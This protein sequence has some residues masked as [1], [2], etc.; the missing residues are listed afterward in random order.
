MIDRLSSPAALEFSE[1]E[2][3]G[4]IRDLENM[5]EMLDELK[6]A[7]APDEL[8]LSGESVEALRSD[9]A[10]SYPGAHVLLLA[11]QAASAMPYISVPK[12][13]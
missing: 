5:T 4:L 12:T 8:P 1:E 7:E 9:T 6:D 11:S 3:P 2:L 13:I 10:V